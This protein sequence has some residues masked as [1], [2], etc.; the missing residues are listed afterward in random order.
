MNISMSNLLSA[1]FF[2]ILLLLSQFVLFWNTPTALIVFTMSTLILFQIIAFPSLV[3]VSKVGA[4]VLASTVLLYLFVYLPFRR[5]DTFGLRSLQVFVILVLGVL[6]SHIVDRIMRVICIFCAGVAAS[7]IIVFVVYFV[8]G[9]L[10]SI[11]LGQNFR[12]N[13][14]DFYLLFPGSIVL[15]TQFFSNGIGS[16]VRTSGFMREPGHFAIFCASVIL[17]YR[18][19]LSRWSTR[20]VAIGGFLTFSP[21]FY[22][23]MVLRLIVLARSKAIFFYISAVAFIF[24]LIY[25]IFPFLPESLQ[26]RYFYQYTDAYMVGGWESVMNQRTRS[27]FDTF[28]NTLSMNEWLIGLGQNAAE[29]NYY[30]NAHSSDFRGFIVTNGLISAIL[31][32][33][34]YFLICFHQGFTRLGFALFMV[35]LLV[36]AHR[37]GFATS[38]W[39]LIF[40]YWAS[41]RQFDK[42][43]GVKKEAA[44][45][46]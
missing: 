34:L 23:F 31:L 16:I 3:S 44:V 11:R 28:Y 12:S 37:T 6:R 10:P 21:F 5:F 38:I 42:G 36:F 22:I 9:T 15:S 7:A 17:F 20:L 35:F 29:A 1:Q 41:S 45:N 32:N 2:I 18:L 24:A 27:D 19:D 33:C 30:F 8:G 13:P 14:T 26:I 43:D 25:F 4:L 46:I 39:F 40:T